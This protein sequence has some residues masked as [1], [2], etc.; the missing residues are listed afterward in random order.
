M[1]WVFGHEASEILGPQLIRDAGIEP[2]IPWIGKQSPN[3][4]AT[5]EVPQ[6]NL[7]GQGYMEDSYNCN[8]CD[9]SV[10]TVETMKSVRLSK[11]IKLEMN[12]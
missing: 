5:R 1:F 3:P 6:V 11:G 2:A 4:W 10:I 8:G 7:V 12:F 9:Q